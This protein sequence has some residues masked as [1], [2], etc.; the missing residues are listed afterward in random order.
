MVA[1]TWWIAARSIA[2]STGGLDYGTAFVVVIACAVCGIVLGITW[3]SNIADVLGGLLASLYDG[4]DQE[5]VPTPF[6]SIAEAK[7]KQGKYLE[8]VAE[9]RK[10]LARFPGD[11]GAESRDFCRFLRRPITDGSAR[12]RHAGTG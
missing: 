12:T 5:V 10:Q 4:G 2:A 3:A 6:Y 1:I 8:S 11:F 9:I 7:R